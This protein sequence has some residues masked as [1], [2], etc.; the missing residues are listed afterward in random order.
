M[1]VGLFIPCYIDQFY[2]EVGIASLQMLEKLNLEVSYPLNQTCCGQPVANSGFEHDATRIYDH[3]IKAFAAYDYIVCPSGSCT[4]HVKE[5]Y[6]QIEQTEQVKKIRSSIY[7]ICEF[8]TDVVNIDQINTA[9]H[10]KVG[11]HKSCHGLRG[12]RQA[13]ASELNT[14]AFSKIEK[15]LN[16]VEG[17][18][19]VPLGREDEC[20][21]FGGT[22]S[23]F[24]EA[25]SVRMGNDRIRDHINHG[26]EVITSADMSCLMHLQGLIDRQKL[27]VRAKHVIEIL[28]GSAL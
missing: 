20:C 18:E 3:F 21:G 17:L 12:L 23:V 9:F 27:P 8:L 4:L 2:P 16:M 5:H 22:F 1:R 26:A 14:A 25:V 13:S 28:N 6:H 11:L 24:E 19:L 7:E 10:H 15:L